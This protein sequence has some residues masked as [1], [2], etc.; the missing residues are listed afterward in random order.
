MELLTLREA[1]QALRVSPITVRRYISAGQ[2]EAVKAGKGVR[3]RK[4]AVDRFLQPVTPRR[5][6]KEPTQPRARLFT[7]DDALFRIVGIA[8][9][10]ADDV[11][12]VSENVD[13]Y[14]A[15]AYADKHV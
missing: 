12:D 10:R 9:G 15:E 2:I 14:L 3:I 4:E 8:N 7:K 1:A 11:T 6:V 5:G 13:K